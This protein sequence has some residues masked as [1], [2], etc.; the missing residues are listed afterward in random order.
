MVERV[1]NVDMDVVVGFLGGTAERDHS[2]HTHPLWLLVEL[3]LEGDGDGERGL[4][5]RP[6][7]HDRGIAPEV[8]QAARWGQR[9]LLRRDGQEHGR[10]NGYVLSV[11]LVRDGQWR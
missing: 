8:V 11:E 3:I 6:R 4:I 7:G 1:L 5:D 2:N 10:R 9:V